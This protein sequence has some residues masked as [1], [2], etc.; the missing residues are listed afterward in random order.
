MSKDDYMIRYNWID[1]ED[2][3]R[4]LCDKIDEVLAKTGQKIGVI[5]G[6]QRGGLIPAVMLSHYFEAPMK[7]LK[8]QTR[9]QDKEKDTHTLH[10][11]LN[12]CKAGEVVLIVDEMADSGKTLYDI[13]EQVDEFNSHHSIPVTV[14]YAVIVQRSSCCVETPIISAN[15]IDSEDWVHFPWEID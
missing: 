2:D 10:R 1:I 9:D 6:I 7:A 12:S 4:F 14:H 5:V 11:V 13:E 8:W 3:I 15:L